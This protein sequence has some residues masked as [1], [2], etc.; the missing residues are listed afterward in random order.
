MAGLAPR[1]DRGPLGISAR[2]PARPHARRPR[3]FLGWGSDGKERGL[4]R[5]VTNRLPQTGDS[6]PGKSDE[7]RVLQ[8][9][10]PRLR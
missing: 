5:K 9:V 3:D 7:S 6:S 10:A 2:T 8:V 1:P 4:Y